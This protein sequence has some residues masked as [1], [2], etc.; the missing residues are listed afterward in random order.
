MMVF[1]IIKDFTG[2]SNEVGWERLSS[3]NDQGFNF[4][5]ILFELN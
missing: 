1:E 4:T 3:V 2:M 5:G